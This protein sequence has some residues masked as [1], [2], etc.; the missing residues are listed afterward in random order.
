M[1]C[2]HRNASAYCG[3]Q[4]QPFVANRLSRTII[5][6]PARTGTVF[7]AKPLLQLVRAHVDELV[8]LSGVYVSPVSVTHPILL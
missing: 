2:L 4:N 6:A 3:R 7:T 8:E 5:F 1:G